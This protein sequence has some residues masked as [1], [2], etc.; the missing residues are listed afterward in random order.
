LFFLLKNQIKYLVNQIK[1]TYFA[2][3]FEK[4]FRIEVKTGIN[5]KDLSGYGKESVGWK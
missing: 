1:I 2:L 4:L 5:V 3:R